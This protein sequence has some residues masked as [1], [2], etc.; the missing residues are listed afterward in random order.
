MERE[1]MK[2]DDKKAIG[3]VVV[4]QNVTADDVNTVVGG[5]IEDGGFSILRCSSKENG[6]KDSPDYDKFF[7]SD[8]ATKM[9]LDGKSL[10]VTDTEDFDTKYELTLD[11]LLK[12]FQINAEK[13]S[14][15]NFFEGD[16]DAI[17][18]DCIIQYAIFGELVYG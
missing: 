16:F 11:R 14:F 18:F 6:F 3:E 10:I 4:K 9:I 1:L 5:W 15:E 2:F 12:G 7:W 8:Y 13:R 17:T